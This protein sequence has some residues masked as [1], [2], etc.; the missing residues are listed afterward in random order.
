MG[1]GGDDGFVEGIDD[2]TDLG[3]GTR[4]HLQDLGDGVFLIA[5][6]DALRAVAAVKIAIKFETTFFLENRNTVFFGAAG[7]DGAFVD[8]EVS[9]L[10]DLAHRGAGSDQ[11]PKIRGL[12]LINRSGDRNDIDVAGFQ[13]KLVG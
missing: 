13:F 2:F 12:V 1:S 10:E 3:S 5:W 6:I 11:G 7:I 9:G 4:R 8:Y